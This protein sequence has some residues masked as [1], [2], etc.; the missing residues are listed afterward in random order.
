M[1]YFFRKSA[2]FGP[3]RLNFSKSGIGASVGVRGARL[4]MTPRGTTYVTVGRHGFYYRETL[5]TRGKQA[6]Q[7]DQ[8]S[9]PATAPIEPRPADEIVTADVSDLVDSSSATLIQRLNERARMFNPAWMLYAVAVAASLGALLMFPAAPENVLPDATTPF[10]PERAA[11]ETDEYSA[12]VAHYGYPNSTLASEPL[13]VVA[14]RTAQYTEAH[15]RIVF[16]P[17]G[18]V[19]EYEEAIRALAERSR[20]PALAKRVPQSTTPCGTSSNVR[21]TIVGYVDS[22]EN[23]AISADSVKL[24]LD[25]ISAKSPSPPIIEVERAPVSKSVNSRRPPK[26][27]SALQPDTKAKQETWALGQQEKQNVA[28]SDAWGLYTRIGLFLAGIGL[29]GMG[30]VVHRSNSEKRISRLFYELDVG[31]HEKYSVVQEA[32]IH[33]GKSRQ[34]WRVEAKSATSDWKRNAG[35]STLLRRS[36][37]SVGTSNP[38]RVETNISIRCIDIGQAKLFFLPDVILYLERGTYGGIPYHDFRVEQSQTR[39]IEDG[40]VPADATVVDRTWRYVNKSGGPDRRFN[41][42]VQLPVAQYGVLVL[43]SSHGL[44]IHLHTS[45]AQES[46]AFANCWRALQGHIGKA[47]ERPLAASRPPETTCADEQAS[48]VLGLGVNASP[49]EISAA[50]RHLA[51]MYHPDKVAGLAPEF[52]VLAEKRMKEINAAYEVLKGRHQAGMP[53]Q[54]EE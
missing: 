35:A 16:V 8:P 49:S 12:L 53:V 52:Q 10:S 54:P 2:S 28:S 38:P 32:L 5:S 36:S 48:R 40:P 30:I 46:L 7:P 37:V 51:Q 23:G 19:A 39:F 17:D 18:C 24:R 41:N 4:T 34:T 21:W 43:A 27:R 9:E 1:G 47:D 20:H 3:F 6:V 15:V 44:N 29:F 11:N 22:T 42:N 45:S 31:E 13:G 25:N 14:V 33:L 26:E 50:Y